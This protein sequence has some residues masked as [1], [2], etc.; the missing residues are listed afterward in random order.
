MG[1]TA[2]SDER[3]KKDIVDSTAGLAF[4]N[5]LD[6]EPFKYKKL[7]NCLKPLTLMKLIQEVFKNSNTQS[8]LY[9]PRS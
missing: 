2:P 6:P 9:S 4:I 1:I 3:Y 7:A 5:D 8:R